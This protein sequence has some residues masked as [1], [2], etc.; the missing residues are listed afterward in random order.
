MPPMGGGGMP[1][2]KSISNGILSNI[3]PTILKIMD[4]KIPFEMTEKPLV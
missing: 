2:Y 4:I 1:E 3:A